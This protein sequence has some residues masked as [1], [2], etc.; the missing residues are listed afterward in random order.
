[1]IEKLKSFLWVMRSHLGYIVTALWTTLVVLR[2]L[3]AGGPHM[4]AYLSMIALFVLMVLA[5][6]PLRKRFKAWGIVW[7]CLALGALLF[8]N[9]GFVN[10]EPHIP[11]RAYLYF[12][13]VMLG[14]FVI[15]L[16]SSRPEPIEQRRP[17]LA[18]MILNGHWE[19]LAKNGVPAD[20]IE[21]LKRLTREERAALWTA[22]LKEWGGDS[23]AQK[24]TSNRDDDDFGL[25]DLTGF[26]RSSPRYNLK[27]RDG[28]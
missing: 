19:L 28:W 5:W 26:S 22:S 6:K 12:N 8:F 1:M 21:R 17:D 10:S 7:S 13:F 25:N 23:S 4:T 27:H 14:C 24:M 18:F 3:R 20:E 11:L 16:L 15:F 9:L 2:V